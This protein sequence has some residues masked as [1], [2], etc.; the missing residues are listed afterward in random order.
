MRVRKSPEKSL[1]PAW[2][3]SIV[4]IVSWL[5]LIGWCVLMHPLS[6]RGVMGSDTTVPHCCNPA[7]LT[8]MPCHIRFWGL[9]LTASIASINHVSTLGL[10]MTITVLQFLSFFHFVTDG[11]VSGILY[12]WKVY[13]I[14]CHKGPRYVSQASGNI[15]AWVLAL[16]FWHCHYPNIGSIRFNTKLETSRMMQT[17]G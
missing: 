14:W 11:S 3:H 1:L 15:R 6:C 10:T 8:R 12:V 9:E 5:V 13:D 4:H 17:E 2:H 7:P 16:P